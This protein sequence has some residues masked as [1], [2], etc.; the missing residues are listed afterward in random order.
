M[1]TASSLAIALA[2]VG[3]AKPAK[4]TP[5]QRLATYLHNLGAHGGAPQKL[6]RATFDQIVVDPFRS[7]YDDYARQPVPALTGP[8]AVRRH[9]AGDLE[10]TP[11]Q[12]RLRWTLPVMYPAYVAQGAVFVEAHGEWRTLAGLDEAMLARIRALDATCAARLATAGPPGPCTDAGWAIADAGLR[13]DTAR[14]TRAC[15]L[16]AT[17]CPLHGLDDLDAALHDRKLARNT[18]STIGAPTVDS[19]SCTK[20][21]YKIRDE[22]GGVIILRDKGCYTCTV[23][24]ENDTYR[25][26]GEYA[27]GLRDEPN[28]FLDAANFHQLTLC[29]HIQQLDKDASDNEMM[30]GGTID[31]QNGGLFLLE[32]DIDLTGEEVVAHELFHLF[33]RHPKLLQYARHDDEWPTD[34]GYVNAYARKSVREDHATVYQYMMAHPKELCEHAAADPVVLTKARLIRARIASVIGDV[35]Y[36]DQRLPCLQ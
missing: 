33:D 29:S 18:A 25:I 23:A 5:E 21:E 12:V 15:Q 32:G 7:L 30:V 2:L 16:A 8:I 22:L 24:P 26:V 31:P 20:P 28:A 13:R 6:D 19:A 34:G 4:P 3:C 35:S 27:R 36:L 10:L 1:G 17:A 9:F 11:A 14:F